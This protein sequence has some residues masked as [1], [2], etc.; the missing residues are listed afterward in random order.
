MH[1]G[2]M[3]IAKDTDK[4]ENSAMIYSST[5]FLLLLKARKYFG[6][7]WKRYGSPLISRLLTLFKTSSIVLS[8]ENKLIKVYMRELM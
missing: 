5:C 4:N 2:L 6:E 7:C 3:R 1:V 8:I